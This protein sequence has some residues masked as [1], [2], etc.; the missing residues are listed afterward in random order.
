MYTDYYNVPRPKYSENYGIEGIS[1][2]P[3]L[4]SVNHNDCLESKLCATTINFYPAQGASKETSTDSKLRNP[5]E[6]KKEMEE[7]KANL[8]KNLNDKHHNL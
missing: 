7:N 2:R 5:C 6:R 4:A 8:E 3:K 1:S